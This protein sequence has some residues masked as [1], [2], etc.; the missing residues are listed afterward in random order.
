MNR[1]RGHGVNG[2]VHWLSTLHFG[3][4]RQ[5]RGGCRGPDPSGRGGIAG[6]EVLEAGD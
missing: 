3:Y 2:H 5:G 4:V 6:K 1:S